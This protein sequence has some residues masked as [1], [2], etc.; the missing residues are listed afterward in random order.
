LTALVPAVILKHYDFVIFAW[1]LGTRG[2]QVNRR[3]AFT[4]IELLVVIAIIAVLIGLLLPAIQKVREAANRMKCSNNLKQLGIA[5]HNYHDAQGAFPPGYQNMVSPQYPN[6]PASR[7]RWSF[8][9]KLTPYLEQTNIYNSLDLTIPLYMDS[10]GGVFPVNQLGV[11][12]TVSL[13]LC[14]SDSQTRVY[15]AF[16]QT[17]Y[18]GCLGNGANGGAR[19]Q[20]NGLFFQN[21]K[22]RLADITDGTSNTAMC[23]EQILGLGGPDV[24]DP[25]LVDV[26]YVY[27]QKSLNADVSD[28]VCRNLT[29]WKTDRGARWADGEVQYEQ[30]DHHYPPNAPQWDCVQLEHSWKPPRS[31]HTS[32]VNVLFADGSE[33]F[34]S[35]SV[36]I[37]TWRAL[38]SRNGGEVLGDY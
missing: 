16:G 31:M 18:A 14:P 7:F 37:D 27:G 24:T 35:N 4:L 19:I 36:N 11:S 25:T 33:H 12:Q 21:S 8:I 6:L 13:L 29:T 9:A 10:Q 28:E 23:S 3:R 26:R 34:I 15:P 32:G 20:A 1:D 17:N 30:Y 22:V 5:V 2:F 38:G